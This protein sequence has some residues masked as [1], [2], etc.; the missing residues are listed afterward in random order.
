MGNKVIIEQKNEVVTKI[1]NEIKGSQ[2]LTIIEYRG[3]SVAKLEQLR[4][5]LRT[6][7]AALKV[8]KNTLVSRALK[9]F[10]Y[11]ELDTQLEGPNAIIFSNNDAVAGPRILAKFAK[12]NKELVIK[13]GVVDGKV[14]DQKAIKTI[15]TLPNKE[16]MI[17]MLLG[18]LQAPVRNFAC[19]IKAVA[20]SKSE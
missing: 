19:I 10:D 16:G 13:A 15:A 5:L 3:L 17:S 7:G 8:Y 12:A 9:S 1:E 6:E 2:S 4:K 11:K 18:C 14:L 20:D